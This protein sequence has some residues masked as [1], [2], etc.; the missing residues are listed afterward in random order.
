MSNQTT[1]ND[2]DNRSRNELIE[3]L[4]SI[5]LANPDSNLIRQRF[6]GIFVRENTG[7][8]QWQQ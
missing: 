8:K 5:W 3:Q 4:R 2:P 7:A 1:K 6:V